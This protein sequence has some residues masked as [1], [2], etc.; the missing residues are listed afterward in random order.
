M[1]QSAAASA[2]RKAGRFAKQYPAKLR[3]SGCTWFG[4]MMPL[5]ESGRREFYTV[6]E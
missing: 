1:T 3:S 5:V 6:V 2:S 4:R